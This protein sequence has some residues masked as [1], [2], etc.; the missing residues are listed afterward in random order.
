[1]IPRSIL[2][3]T[4]LVLYSVQIKGQVNLPDILLEEPL[5]VQLNY[6]EERTRIYE[7]YRAIREDM[8]Q[9]IKDNA[10]DSL[11][12]AKE[13]IVALSGDNISLTG[14]LDSLGSLIEA[15]REELESS[16]RTKNRI[17]VFG[18]EVNKVVYNSVILIVIAVLIFILL[19]GFLA[20][21]RHLTIT[22]NLKKD[23]TELK[24]EYEAYRKS[25][26]EARE[27]M[28]MDHFNELKRLKNKFNK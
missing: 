18:F 3:A 9:K 21:R 17:R 2:I 13:R 1:M 15:T 8:F 11:A 6:I 26:R 16:I 25:T 19:T 23:I 7:N 4:L 28:S 12:A 27:K 20:F 24:E 14:T 5:D 22:K 10:N